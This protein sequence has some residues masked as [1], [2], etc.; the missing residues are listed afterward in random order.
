VRTAV[1][2]K[3]GKHEPDFYALETESVIVL[4]WDREVLVNG[5]LMPNPK[6]ADAS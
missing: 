4:P 3:T 1:S 5:E 6:Y 2:F